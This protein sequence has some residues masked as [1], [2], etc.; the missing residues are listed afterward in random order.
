MVRGRQSSLVGDTGSGFDPSASTTKS[1][2]WRRLLMPAEHGSWA[3]AFEPVGLGLLVAYSSTAVWLGLAIIFGFFTRK[4]VK[5]FLGH[6][7]AAPVLRRQACLV[8]FILG[9][10]GILTLGLAIMSSSGPRILLPLALA[11]PGILFFIRHE[12]DGQTRSVV[13]ELV[14]T[15]LCSLPLV[16][17][18]LAAN[19]AWPPAI[20]L[21]VVNLARAWPTVLFVRVRLRSVRGESGLKFVAI[22]TQFLAPAV[23][24][25]LA[26]IHCIPWSVVAINAV[27]SIRALAFLSGRFPSVS[28]RKIGIMEVFWGLAHVSALTVVYVVSHRHGNSF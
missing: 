10:L 19:W 1:F 7:S 5:I 14:G 15:G 3:F 11:V 12:I 16:S 18:A 27:L 2:P 23:L 17:I 8:L 6:N 24:T 4:P 20:A 21:G 26:W 22:I 9:A 13:A 28:A 25:S